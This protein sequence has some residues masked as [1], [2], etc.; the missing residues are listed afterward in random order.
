M[1][2]KWGSTLS[3]S[4]YGES[5]CAESFLSIMKEQ[6]FQLAIE[7]SELIAVESRAG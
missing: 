2:K 3:L 7:S 6:N 5:S 4:H 1:G